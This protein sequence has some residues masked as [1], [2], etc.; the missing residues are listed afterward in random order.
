MIDDERRTELLVERPARKHSRIDLRDD[1]DDGDEEDTP[2]ETPP[3]VV[4][5]IEMFPSIPLSVL[6]SIW[7]HTIKATDLIKLY[8]ST[9]LH[10]EE[11]SYR[12]IELGFKKTIH[13]LK[14]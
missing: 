3:A 2:R 7:K 4:P 1:E 12:I 13:S 8:P 10:P 6:I 14:D 11:Q 9:V 5:L